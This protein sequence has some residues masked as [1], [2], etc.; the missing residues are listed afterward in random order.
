MKI[1]ILG[2]AG[3]IVWLGT[4]FANA[5]EAVAP[6]KTV[7]ID[8]RVKMPGGVSLEDPGSQWASASFTL[9]GAAASTALSD[10]TVL[11]D[12]LKRNKIR[13]DQIVLAKF[14]EALRSPDVFAKIAAESPHA[15]FRMK[16]NE[17]GLACA[18]DSTDLRPI[19]EIESELS[20]EGGKTLW[21]GVERIDRFDSRVP[22]CD[23]SL[24][25]S[26]GRLLKTGF[27]QAAELAVA[28]LVRK[29]LRT[30]SDADRSATLDAAPPSSRVRSWTAKKGN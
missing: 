16:V 26:D 30:G 2:L 28:R 4:G 21:K 17:Y 25:A 10:K 7:R 27:S 24:Y 12:Q 5:A 1:R 29:F 11:D 8:P 14:S 15:I 6:A 18:R 13:V 22:A 9:A 19:L 20:A 3:A 23:W